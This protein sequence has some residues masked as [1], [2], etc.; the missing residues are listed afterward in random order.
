MEYSPEQQAFL[1]HSPTDSARV[2][3]GPGTGKS[4]TSVA[5]LER[6]IAANPDLR[7]GY[8]TFTRAAT[9]EFAKKLE[10][11]ELSALGD[12]RPSTVH[13]FALGVLMRQRS[14]RLPYPL[15]IPD[16]WEI[17][18]LIE[19]DLKARLLARGSNVNIRTIR[20]L[21][22]ELAAGFQTLSTTRSKLAQEQPDLVSAFQGVWRVHRQ[23]YGYTLLSE[24]PMQAGGVLQDM[25]EAGVD[26][27]LLIVDEYQ[28]LNAADQRLL[29]EVAHRSVA[30]IA[31]G[32]DDQSIYSWRN[33]APDGIRTFLS[34]FNASADY[35]LTLSQRCGGRALEVAA[36]LIEQDSGRAP[37]PRLTPS[38]RANPTEFGYLRY[39]SNT[40]EARGVADIIARRLASGVAPEE[41]AVLVRSSANT[42]KRELADHLAEREIPVQDTTDV[43]ATFAE[44]GFRR[45]LAIAHLMVNRDDSLA[46]RSLLHLTAGIG[47]AFI[48][49]VEADTGSPIFAGRLRNLIRDDAQNSSAARKAREVVLELEAWLDEHSLEAVELGDDGW[50]RWLTD[51]VQAGE[52]TQAAMDL[53]ISADDLLQGVSLERFLAELQPTARDQA[54]TATGGVRIMSMSQ[55]K[56]LTVN[57]AIVMGVEAQNIPR[58]GCDIDEERR[59]LYVAFTRATHLTVATF[60]SRRTG[61]TARVGEPRVAQQRERSPFLS[62]LDLTPSDGTA[63]I[64]PET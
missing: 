23:L 47:P 60:A 53:L 63:Y 6:A 31:I 48:R 37:K 9:A 57:T 26:L 18:E 52:L 59:L 58:P 34:T 8:V 30:I 62:D 61:G 25:D 38:D 54:V 20:E 14:A 2:L 35:P 44:T 56:G 29:E 39:R 4:F 42:W 10:D 55:S 45:I 13:G 11:A 49:L 51:Y 36:S 40:A 17:R 33:A 7:V 15:R 1:A 21:L 32:D 19:P 16:Q 43:D 28:D 64:P 22:Q 3:A 27:D 46:W 24:L 12:R 50:G 5:Y 41:I